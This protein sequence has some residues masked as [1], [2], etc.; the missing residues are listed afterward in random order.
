MVMIE[1][2]NDRSCIRP[3]LRAESV[4]IA[5]QQRRSP[6]YGSNFIFVNRAFCESGYE[7]IPDTGRS[8]IPHWSDAAVPLIEI[9]Y[10]ADAHRVWSPHAK[11]H[12]RNSF[13]GSRMRAHFFVL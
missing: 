5:L 13:D 3:E 7:Q 2:R 1:A 4:R 8:T 6:G 9:S 10:H 11:L 12:A